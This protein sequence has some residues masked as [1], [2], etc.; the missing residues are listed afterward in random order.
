M[1]ELPLTYGIVASVTL[2]VPVQCN[3]VP[4]QQQPHSSTCQRCHWILN[5]CQWRHSTNFLY[6]NHI[7]AAELVSNFDHQRNTISS[8]HLKQC[9]FIANYLDHPDGQMGHPVSRRAAFS[10]YK[11]PWSSG[12]AGLLQRGRSAMTKIYFQGQFLFCNESY[13]T[14]RLNLFFKPDPL[15]HKEDGTPWSATI[16]KLVVW[17]SGL[18]LGES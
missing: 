16:S 15:L 8:E 1:L 14:I 13:L 4:V 10:F 11:R 18:I 5:Q 2:G 17:R 6:G 3:S 12:W 7:F 9:R